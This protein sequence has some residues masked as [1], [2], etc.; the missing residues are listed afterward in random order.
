ML[1]GQPGQHDHGDLGHVLL[2]PV[3]AL[4]LV[5]IG[6]VKV[7][8]HAGCRRQQRSGLGDRPHPV[9]GDRGSRFH[10]VFLD[11]KGVPIIVL[12]EQH[13]HLAG[14]GRG[15]RGPG[16][17]GVPS[18]RPALFMAFVGVPSLTG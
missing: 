7:E 9:K 16:L 15:G 6:E 11:E 12:D 2:Q 18:H 14:N 17:C 10:Q 13:L 4:Q 1:I 8:Q 3:Q 5:R